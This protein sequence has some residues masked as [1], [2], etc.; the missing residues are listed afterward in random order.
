M[1]AKRS[2]STSRNPLCYIREIVPSGVGLLQAL[3]ASQSPIIRRPLSEIQ[4]QVPAGIEGSLHVLESHAQ[5]VLIQN[6]AHDVKAAC[7]IGITLPE[8]V[9]G[10]HPSD[11]S[12]FLPI[13]GRPGSAEVVTAPY[14][15]FYEDKLPSI[16]GDDVYL[17]APE[18]V[19]S[20]KNPHA[21]ERQERARRVFTPS[22]E[23][24][25]VDLP[26]NHLTSTACPGGYA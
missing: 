17:K 13:H 9:A 19:V 18:L 24:R 7:P 1:F 8:N 6:N 4:P 22:T 3:Q 12:L 26:S 23:P 14:L 16:L 2:L 5:R 20:L 11:L 15:D 25:S 21:F 10:R